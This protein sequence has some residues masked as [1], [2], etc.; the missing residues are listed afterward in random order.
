MPLAEVPDTDD[1]DTQRSKSAP[2]SIGA[3]RRRHQRQRL[4]QQ[5][6]AD[7]HRRQRPTGRY[8]CGPV[9][10]EGYQ[11][12]LSELCDLDSES[13]VDDERVLDDVRAN[14][15]SRSAPAAMVLR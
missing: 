13:P 10:A 12:A 7:E 15:E 5:R 14:T 4:N 1:S 6:N 8:R 2:S 9:G 11:V 3:L